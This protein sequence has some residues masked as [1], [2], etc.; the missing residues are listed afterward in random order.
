MKKTYILSGLDC[1]HCSAEIERDVGK[2]KGIKYSNVNLVKQTLTIEFDDS[3]SGDIFKAIEKTVHKHESDVEIIEHS[4]DKKHIHSEEHHHGHTHGENC[5]CEHEN[6]HCEG[7]YENEHNDKH[8]FHLDTDSEAPH[9]PQNYR[10][11]TEEHHPLKDSFFSEDNSREKIFILQGLDCAHCSA[12]IEKGV[13]K[14]DGVTAATINLVKQLLTVEYSS[15]YSG[16]IFKDVEK[17]VHKYEPD[18]EVTE[19]SDSKVKNTAV[20]NSENVKSET[21]IKSLKK[22]MKSDKAIVIRFAIGAVIYAIGFSMSLIG[23]F[24]NYLILPILIAAYLILGYDVLLKAFKNILKGRIFDENFLMTVSTLGAFVIGEYPEAVAVMLFYQIGE[25]FQSLAVKR[26]RKSISQLMDIRPDSANVKRSGKIIMVPPEDVEIGEAIVIKPGEKI[27]LDGVVTD[28]E[29]MINTTALT[30][31]SVPRKV[32]SGDSVL[33][34]CINE[35]GV[36]T[37]KVTKEFNESTASKILELVENAASRKAPAENFITTFS[38]YYTP[39]VVI[40]ATLLAIVPP[41]FLGG[42]WATWIHRCFVFL[43]ISCPCALVISIPLTFFGGIGAASK[44]GILIKG[45]NYLEALNDVETIVFDKTGTLTKGVFNVTDTVTANGFSESNL[46]EFAAK[47]ES[48]SNHPIARSI[49]CEYKNNINKNSVKNYS[50]ISGH[51]VSAEID[52]YK[53]LAGNEKLMNKNNI[54]FEKSEKVGTTVYVAVDGKYAGCVVIS[55]EIKSD[56]KEAIQGLKNIGIAKTV[57]LTGD[58][59]TIAKSVAEEIGITEYYGDLLPDQKVERFEQLYSDK[60]S[61]KKLAFVGDGINDA[62]VLARADVGIA[63]GALGSDAAIEAADVVLMTD[64]PS[65]LIDAIKVA[66]CTKRIVMQNIVFVIAVKVLFLILGAFGIAGMWE[67]VFGDVG[68][69]IIA[70]INSMRI[71][72]TSLSLTFRSNRKS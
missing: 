64:E 48:M 43:V 13:G 15:D 46:L 16:D 38:R 56:S 17:V 31:E 23:G 59:D 4:S 65:K 42:G 69:M 2:L 11:G 68:V 51:G 57:M 7:E 50:E 60:S 36:L 27:P 19:K 58:S 52:G 72:S 10:K 53:V 55:D 35:N 14:L 70:V 3:Y 22:T 37:V 21:K 25:F 54:R 32:K 18:V 8:R 49:V 45:S 66:H 30:G 47:A 26:S 9:H 12:E 28:G 34:G 67:A 20:G 71:I 41:L 1:P 63:M 5:D 29:A 33:S 40:M 24:S 39:V 62:P 61:N 44:E 6:T